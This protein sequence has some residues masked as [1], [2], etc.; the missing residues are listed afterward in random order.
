MGELTAPAAPVA[1][2]PPAPPPPEHE[3]LSAARLG[4][5]VARQ[6]GYA[7]RDF[8][9][10]PVLA[11]V[12]L[13][14]PL[15]F[16]FM[17]GLA[18]RE[19][20]LDP[21]TGASA[22]QAMAPI[23]AVFAAVMSAYVMLPFG[24]SRAREL[25]VLKRLRGTPLPRASYLVGRVLVAAWV[26]ALGT[27]LM[28]V[29]AALAFDLVLPWR[30]VPAMLLTFVVGV[31]CFAALGVAAAALLRTSTA[32]LAFTMGSFLLVAFA[33]GVFSPDLA[34]PRPLDIASWALPLRHFS[35]AFGG[36]FA[37]GD[38]AGFPWLHLGTLV[39]WGA[40]G[41]AL[42]ARS[43]WRDP[44]PTGTRG[45]STPEP[46]ARA[47]VAPVRRDDHARRSQQRATR[48]PTG[49][50][51]LAWHQFRYGNHQ[52]WREPSSVFFA[53]LFPTL[54]VVVVP[55]AFG[56]PVLDGVPFAAMVT[57]SMAVFG[58][59]VTAY[60]NMPEQVALAREKG[61]LKRLRGT[62]LPAAAY[63]T[64][65]LGSTLWVGALAVVGAYLA[66]WL[67]HG[68]TVPWRSL[69]AIVVVFLVGIPALAAL[70]LAIVA[71]VPE[72]KMV[73]AVALGTFLPLAFISGMFAFG[74]ELPGA[75]STVGWVFP[76]KHLVEAN[77]AAFSTATVT[78]GNLGVVALWGLAG[79]GVAAWRFRW[80]G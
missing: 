17:M 48:R 54:F 32:V 68:V 67:V 23:A 52:V 79:A 19:V 57:P 77:Q 16:L 5:I 56:Q 46:R 80:D 47:A 35:E 61:V 59:V 10:N 45:R 9:R 41:A 6:T 15:A 31:A 65:R 62:P 73:P 42:G 28:L 27:V 33:S 2:A 3:R 55:Y 49:F 66:G 7:H 24:I 76:F 36:T 74:F 26:A 37:L 8:W 78:L 38:A 14:F 44:A 69:P 4:R 53:V 20:P 43:L 34:L 70:G 64:G 22:I 11:F 40:V 63:L 13:G 60:V 12:T 1:D 39:A 29:V 30:A 71:L 51:V 50:A 25:G 58:A 21:V 75:L 72:A 18:S